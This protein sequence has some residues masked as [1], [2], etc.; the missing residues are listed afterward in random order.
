[1]MDS[2]ARLIYLML[3]PPA[4]SKQVIVFLTDGQGIYTFAADGGPASEAA[5]KGYRIYAIGLEAAAN[6]DNLFDMANATN[7]QNYTDIES[8]DLETIFMDIFMD[9]VLSTIPRSIYVE[10]IT[11]DY[12]VAD[13]DS[14]TPPAATCEADEDTSK[15]TITWNDIGLLSDGDSMLMADETV[16]LTFR[17]FSTVD[18]NVGVNDPDAQVTYQ[19]SVGNQGSVPIPQASS[20]WRI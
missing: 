11:L 14:A 4:H 10:E 8:A 18:G 12:I 19:D 16:T 6:A 15:P 7:G 13:C 5:Q 20:N 9:V 2:M 1:M 17:A 3:T